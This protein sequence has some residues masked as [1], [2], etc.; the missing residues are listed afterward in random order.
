MNHIEYVAANF[1][2]VGKYVS[3]QVPGEKKKGL[4]GT[5]KTTYKTEKR[6][7]QTGVSNSLIDGPRLASD[8]DEKTREL[9]RNGFEVIAITPITSGNY[10]YSGNS[11]GQF[12]YGYGY[13]YTEGV[14]IL[15]RKE[16]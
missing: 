1:A 2:P 7:K 5:E 10:N 9:N 15:A 13:G 14:V 3:V 6:F 8:I 11:Q 12:G 16:L 4:F